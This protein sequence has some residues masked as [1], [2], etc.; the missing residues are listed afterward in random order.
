M[1]GG[2]E[3]GGRSLELLGINQ[4]FV[5]WGV[6]AEGERV[7]EGGG[8]VEG[9]RGGGGNRVLAGEKSASE[10]GNGAKEGIFD[11][12]NKGINRAPLLFLH[13]RETERSSAEHQPPPPFPFA[14]LFLPR[15]QLKTDYRLLIDSSTISPPSSIDL[16][17]FYIA[18][19]IYHIL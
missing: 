6:V 16:G 1:G 15:S 17:G 11:G 8:E 7:K 3:G 9:G 18:S 13:Q 2:G 19:I 4:T 12:I 10:P 14:F 5:F